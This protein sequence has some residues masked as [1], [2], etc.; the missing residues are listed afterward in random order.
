MI[1]QRNW[2]SW[3]AFSVFFF[4][5]ERGLIQNQVCSLYSFLGRSSQSANHADCS[6]QAVQT[7]YFFSN[8]WLTF[9]SVSTVKN[10][11]QCVLVF[12]IYPQAAHCW[13]NRQ[14]VLIDFL[15]EISFTGPK[16]TKIKHKNRLPKNADRADR[17][18]RPWRLSTNKLHIWLL[19]Q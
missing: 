18:Y 17:L 11:V 14:T 16:Y 19:I 15:W 8:T 2:G 7:E 3:H 6:L 1:L 4:L 5:F 13:F 9:F 10:S 12:V